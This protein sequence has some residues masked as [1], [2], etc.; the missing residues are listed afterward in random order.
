[1][2]WKRTIDISRSVADDPDQ[3]LLGAP[4]SHLHERP[5]GLA[6]LLGVGARAQHFEKTVAVAVELQFIDR[7]VDLVTRCGRCRAA[8]VLWFL[9]L[10]AEQTHE[11]LPVGRLWL[12]RCG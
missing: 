2:A 12:R 4:V 6:A 8:R 5:C 3:R 10:P 9:G 7:K 11:N 1:M